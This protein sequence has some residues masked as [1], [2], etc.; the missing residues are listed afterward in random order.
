VSCLIVHR[1][2]CGPTDSANGGYLCGLL[3]ALAPHPVTVRLLAPPPLDT[4][5]L[6]RTSGDVMELMHGDDVVA[7]ARPGDVGDLIPP[8]TPSREAAT[9]ASRRY[10]GFSRDHP[11]PQCF[12]CGPRRPSNDGLAIFPGI[13]EEGGGVVAAPWTPDASLDA[14]DGKVR[15]EFSWAALDCS[16]YHAFAP[17]LRPM[18]LGEMTARLHRSV[19][20]GEPCVVIG[21]RIGVQ[22]RKHEAGTALFG[23]DGRLC[24][25]ARAVWIELRKP[26]T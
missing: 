21:W 15:P 2:F 5:L 4:E 22:G 23:A 14:G 6:V 7:T 19:A 20:V 26:G 1:R 9:Q 12:V 24:G 10:A 3:A 16:G 13:L 18:L 17:D 25:R 11:A 8:S